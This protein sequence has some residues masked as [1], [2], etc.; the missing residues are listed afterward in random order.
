MPLRLSRLTFCGEIDGGLG[1]AQSVLSKFDPTPAKRA[2]IVTKGDISA[3]CQGRR[4]A[5]E[6]ETYYRM[7]TCENKKWDSFIVFASLDAPIA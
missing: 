5:A 7:N 4:Q 3:T 2:T 6:T 1:T